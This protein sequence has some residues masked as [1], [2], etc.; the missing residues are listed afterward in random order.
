MRTT[1]SR[2]VIA[3]L[4]I[5]AIP[6]IDPVYSNPTGATIRHGDIQLVR[7][8]DTLRIVQGTSQGIIDWNS[9]SIP[10]GSTTQFLQPG[11]SSATLNRVTGASLSQ[12]NGNLL[13]NGR[14]LL[15]N[16]N[17]IVIG[18]NGVVDTGGFTASTLDLSNANFLAG[19]DFRFQGNSNAAV[20]NLGSINAVQG[21]VFLVASSVLNEGSISAPN[22]TVGLAAGNDVL[23]AETGSER[24]FVRGSGVASDNSGVINKGTVNANVAE[25][26][27]HGGNIY[28]M[29]VKNEGR[30]AATAVS[31][32]G[33]QIFLRAGGGGRVRSTGTLVAK[34]AESGGD[35]V[36][37]SGPH[38][39]TQ[40]G[41]VVDAS[42]ES[43]SGGEILILGSTINVFEDSLIIADGDSGGGRILVG[44]GR[45]GQNPEF[46]NATD[47][48]VAEGA[49][50][51]AS[52][53]VEGDGGELI[54]FAENRLDF[55]GTVASTGGSISGDGGFIE[56][57][58]KN[59]IL[60][61]NLS[62]RVFLSAA[63][64]NGGTLLFDP[65]NVDVIVGTGGPAGVNELLEDDI[66]GVLEG[67]A[68]FMV[69]TSGEGGEG[70]ITVFSGVDLDWT[71]NNKLT[72]LADRDFI[73]QRG[74]EIIAR[75]GG[76]VEITATRSVDIGSSGTFSGGGITTNTGD[77]T[78]S[79]NGDGATMGAF[80]AVN[81][82]T[83]IQTSDGK[84]SITGKSG[85]TSGAGVIVAGS[86][87]TTSTGTGSILL[88]GEAKGPGESG[89]LLS[90][91]GSVISTAGADSSITLEANTI[92]LAAGVIQ[93]PGDLFI[94]PL[95]SNTSINLGALAT[96]KGL[97]L[98]DLEIGR[99]A[100]GFKSI[101][102]GSETLTSV[103][104][105]VNEVT[106]TDPLTLLTP[107]S[108]GEI[109]VNG[110]LSGTGNASITLNGAGPA[111]TGG[112]PATTYLSAGISTQGERIFIDD[113]V[114]LKANAVLNTTDTVVEGAD[115]VILG[116]VI[117]DRTDIFHTFT[118]NAG[119]DGTIGLGGDVGVDERSLGDVTLT[120]GDLQL[121]NRLTTQGDLDITVGTNFSL[122]API[123]AVGNVKIHANQGPTFSSGNFPG[124]EISSS[125]ESDTGGIELF[126][127]GG[128]VDGEEADGNRG[129]WLRS[130]SGLTADGLISIKGTTQIADSFGVVI[131][132]P[133]TSENGGVQIA[134]GGGD[135]RVANAINA[136]GAVEFST[137]S[138]E[139]VEFLIETTLS[140][141]LMVSFSGGVGTADTVSYAGSTAFYDDVS[142]GQLQ[143]IEFLIG[144]GNDEDYFYG[145]DTLSSTFSFTGDGV[146]NYSDT[147][148]NTFAV[149]G[150]EGI[151]GGSTHDTFEFDPGGSVDMIS[152]EGGSDTVDF[153]D[154][155]EN[156]FVDAGLG[157]ASGIGEFESIEQFIGSTAGASNGFF[158]TENGDS[159]L[160]TGNG[161]GFLV[162]STSLG[163]ET[164]AI[165]TEGID[166]RGFQYIDGSGGDDF[167][168]IEMDGVGGSNFAGTLAGG[169]GDDRFSLFTGSV[170]E[171][172]GG[173]RF[174]LDNGPGRNTIDLSG[175]DFFSVYVDLENES[176]SG[177]S[178]F[179]DIDEFVAGGG[180]YND[181]YGTDGRDLFTI[182]GSSSGTVSYP[183]GEGATR[184]ASFSGFDYIG[185]GGGNDD[186]TINLE[187]PLIGPAS[188][189]FEPSSIVVPEFTGTLDGG[190]GSDSFLFLFG[191]VSTITGGFSS[192]FPS[193]LDTL[194]FS[195]LSDDLIVDLA[196]LSALTEGKEF[197]PRGL[198]S[199]DE[200]V[201]PNPVIIGSIGVDAFSEIDHIVGGTGANTLRATEG[202][203]AIFIGAG[204]DGSITFEDPDPYGGAPSTS[205]SSSL[206]LDSIPAPVSYLTVGFEGFTEIDGRAGDDVFTVDLSE[207]DIGTR[208]LGGAGSDFFGIEYYEF[209]PVSSVF[210]GRVGRL[211]EPGLV[212]EIEGSSDSPDDVDTLNFSSFESDVS[213]DI[214]MGAASGVSSFS[215]IEV[216]EGGEG[217]N[218]EFTGTAGDDTFTLSETGTHL[219]EY[220]QEGERQAKFSGFES[221]QGGTGANELVGTEGEDAFLITGNGSGEVTIPLLAPA[222]E[223]GDFLTSEILPNPTAGVEEI[224]F[225]DVALVSGSGGNDVFE[226]QLPSTESFDGSLDGGAG[227][228]RFAISQGGAVAEILG[229]SETDTL[230]FSAFATPVNVN[231]ASTSAT[232][233]GSFSS[234]ES[235]VGGSA[236]DT[237]LGTNGSDQFLIVRDDGGFLNSGAFDGF[238]I[239]RGLGGTDRFVFT[240]QATV[241]N[242]VGGSG[243][244]TF[245][246]DD[247]NLGGTNTYTVNGNSVSRNPFY[248]FSE[249]EF[250]QLF[251]GPGDDTVVTDDNSLI[252]V[253]NGGGGTDTIDFGSTPVSGRAPF[254]FGGTQVFETQFENFL[255]V[256]DETNNPENINTQLPGNNNPLGDGSLIDQFTNSGGLGEAVGNAFAAFATNAIIA[257]Q[258]GLIQ[259]DG[260]EYQL[261]APASLDGFF[262]QP[263]SAIIAQLTRNLEVDAWAELADAID[264]GGATIMVYSD[265]PYS[266]S[267][268]GVPPDQIIAILTQA[269]LA[270]AATELI[271]ALELAIVIPITS[272]DGAV[273]ILTIPVQIDPETLNALMN[274]LNEQAFSEL[275]AALGG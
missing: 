132:A 97:Q 55:S 100:D 199:P 228:D 254:V 31:H 266:I 85:D 108:G 193:D 16:P 200:L 63:N 167:F 215:G 86:I 87:T 32:E 176:A 33:G 230:D 105:N 27:A 212:M 67:G 143:N 183:F 116:T 220:M 223:I 107:N 83:D 237:L 184:M 101:T 257:G 160:I 25:L 241:S 140:E 154:F 258:A 224:A 22:G 219:L 41:G 110:Q 11:A 261:Q 168:S 164:G 265:G 273:S 251:L 88:S 72:F 47:V 60:I 94:R 62:S 66:I 239:L 162:T 207:G 227:E 121:E 205:V 79:A 240:E 14:V 142:A 23:I 147:G 112:G 231:I 68:D 34:K 158:G 77:I 260:G 104:I 128:E 203:D 76:S 236:E 180:F 139:S 93:S 39:E 238:E 91:T 159:F 131:E 119:S 151:F 64:G 84:I 250:I 129:V 98:S 13:A 134:S 270:D 171:I 185:G 275:T 136:P 146:F 53:R 191:N 103:S 82:V 15:L 2:V 123:F 43:G 249:I 12:I 17:G 206:T 6:F 216:F 244:D 21:D 51:D 152:G 208:L 268:D 59:E 243:V 188:S 210:E 57:S 92:D 182:T 149:S 71:G 234:I 211:R 242:F 61:P 232:Q 233:V 155:G 118:I 221:L 157:E 40:I 127:R 126:G 262:T 130:G 49:M 161:R 194:D 56:L 218:D 156:V 225:T 269:L 274:N 153:T 69:E 166:F 192:G 99:L 179:Q 26:K 20:V 197:R 148:G 124:I 106:F 18:R 1:R 259:I 196:D 213:V 89:I 163:V 181:F 109:F 48:T 235:V 19:G 214:G 111:G 46:M 209:L 133:V 198:E 229:G 95:S 35:V 120:A 226:V 255:L 70:D 29:A 7:S 170:Q 58:G 73:L 172:L 187:L 4:T 5:L 30:V 125:I 135:V 150:F 9:F 8:G 115:V 38:S 246:L 267:L 122:D 256:R 202:V 24:V 252:Q 186:F 28:G 10:G 141:S 190:A 245:V 74:A 52:A 195:G 137:T 36:V 54:I 189:L 3:I 78:I 37:E 144:N 117:G 113:D 138:A 102:I 204:G 247:R 169:E 114:V 50:F 263:P 178:S 175:S 177:V 165:I 96:D 272:I 217:S 75:D 90:Q 174:P 264:F 65:R 81:V 248:Q 44:G 145:A 271:D 222:K 253:L 173:S 45:R 80:S 42:G 201:V